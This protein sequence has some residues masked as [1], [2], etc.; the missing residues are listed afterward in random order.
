[1]MTKA[2]LFIQGNKNNGD[3]NNNS[4]PGTIPNSLKI[5]THLIL[6]NTLLEDVSDMES[7]I[8][9]YTCNHIFIY[10]LIKHLSI[11]GL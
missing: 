11:L 7:Q 6:T 3:S 5:L 8:Y 1:M 10:L 9:I 4:K 2:Q